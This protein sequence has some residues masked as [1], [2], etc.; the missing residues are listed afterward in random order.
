MKRLAPVLAWLVALAC[1][2]GAAH[3]LSR[4]R[5]LA[6]ISTALADMPRFALKTIPLGLADYQAIEKK[7]TLFGTVKIVPGP[8]G[9][10]VKAMAISDYAAW[11]LTVDQ[12]LLDNP[13]VAWRIDY[14]CSGKCPTD[15]AH[16]ALLTGSRRV[17]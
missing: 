15:E 2:A 4:H 16:Q 13:G 5:K 10:S 1:L 7:T 3:E 17:P 14:L 11:R 12:V 9:L 8:Q 6:D